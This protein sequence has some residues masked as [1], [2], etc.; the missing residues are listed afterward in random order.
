MENAQSSGMLNYFDDHIRSLT[1]PAKREFVDEIQKKLGYKITD[2]VGRVQPFP[3]LK[4][5][6]QAGMIK[7]ASNTNRKDFLK[8]LTSG[9]NAVHASM[10][11][12]IGKAN[13]NRLAI[14]EMNNKFEKSFIRIMNDPSGKEGLE[15]FTKMLKDDAQNIKAKL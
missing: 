15:N 10:V 8:Q 2:D 12:S 1:G 13:Y 7:A 6:I 9:N 5:N 3:G 14:N 11:K 4:S